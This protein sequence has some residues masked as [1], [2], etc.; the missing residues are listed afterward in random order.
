M[1]MLFL[2]SIYTIYY[3]LMVNHL[4]KDFVIHPIEAKVEPVELPPTTVVSPKE[5]NQ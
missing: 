5:N 2:M 4:R 3:W 1:V